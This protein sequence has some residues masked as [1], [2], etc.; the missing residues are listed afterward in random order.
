[1]NQT[2]IKRVQRRIG[3]EDDGDWGPISTHGARR[4]LLSMM[5]A[6]RFPAMREVRSDRSV[7]GPH[8]DP[9]GY[10]PPGRRIRLPFALHLYGDPARK[11]LWLE[12]HER[13]ADAMLCAFQR[14]AAAFP[15]AEERKAAGVLDYYGLYNP[16]PIRGGSVWSMHAYRIAI[17]LDA[18]R[19]KNRSHWPVASKMPIEVM[20]CFAKEGFLAAGAFWSR[21]AMHFQATAA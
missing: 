1:M 9:G 20:E 6:G 19:N 14:L 17:D 12:P 15:T 11:V 4:H 3:V 7:F 2:E 13:C 16:R 10:S 8:G 21:D 5:P 18:A